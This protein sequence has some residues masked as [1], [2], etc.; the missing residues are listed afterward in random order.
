MERKKNKMKVGEREITKRGRD[1]K[2]IRKPD[3]NYNSQFAWKS[4]EYR[5]KKTF[6]FH[7]LE[8]EKPREIICIKEREKLFEAGKNN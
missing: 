6:V 5:R 8:N 7:C 3:A 4:F 1:V 2:M